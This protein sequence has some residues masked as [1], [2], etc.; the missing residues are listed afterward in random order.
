M[1]NTGV[2]K[3]QQTQL[4]LPWQPIPGASATIIGLAY[5][6][7]PT[8]DQWADHGAKLNLADRAVDWL[9]GDWFVWGEQQFG[10]I[11]Y[12]ALDGF[13]PDQIRKRVFVASRIPLSRRRASLSFTH[14]ALVSG[15]K[16]DEQEHWLSQT[17]KHNLTTKELA[18]S[19]K[20]GRI[21]TE[22]ELEAKTPQLPSLVDVSLAF[23][24][25]HWSQ[26]K[27]Q[28]WEKRGTINDDVKRAWLDV[29]S[30]PARM[31]AQLTEELGDHK[32]GNE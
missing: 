29:L 31:Y 11:A 9:V 7:T 8:F 18:A 3:P 21:V 15:L 2:S 23:R 24:S 28:Q 20:H 5:E 32:G 22:L 14:H 1:K 4:E 26:W 25:P 13:M 17:E 12:Q 19:I 6:Q 27:I 16:P 30:E 10:E